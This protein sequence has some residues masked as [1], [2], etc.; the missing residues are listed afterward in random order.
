MVG[1][2][3][4]GLSVTPVTVTAPPGPVMVTSAAPIEPALTELVSV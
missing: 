4:A 2:S 1:A 3:A